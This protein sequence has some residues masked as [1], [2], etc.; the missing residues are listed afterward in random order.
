MRGM[1]M[2]ESTVADFVRRFTSVCAQRTRAQ[3]CSRHPSSPNSPAPASHHD[4][5]IAP[6]SPELTVPPVLVDVACLFMVGRSSPHCSGIG[7]C[8][9]S[10][11]EDGAC[12]GQRSVWIIGDGSLPGF[13][14][15]GP[16]RRRLLSHRRTLSPTLHRK[17]AMEY[18]TGYRA[19]SRTITV[20]TLP[21]S[22][23][24]FK[25]QI[26]GWRSSRS[27]NDHPRCPESVARRSAL[28][29]RITAHRPA[30]SRRLEWIGVGVPASGRMQRLAAR[31]HQ[32]GLMN[33]RATAYALAFSTPQPHAVAS[34]HTMPAASVD[35][36][37]TDATYL[38]S[39]NRVWAATLAK[40]DG[41]RRS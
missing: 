32:P 21:K 13:S 2:S 27:T 11:A 29:P 30:L 26:R 37:R 40:H 36:M 24:Y 35:V 9:T 8:K 19:R 28:S 12:I 17:P 7:R 38:Y 39:Q 16:H 25:L 34:E 6:F 1:Y 22:C 10:R 4:V 14:A 5:T 18:I 3:T 33:G 15:R 20:R 23:A 41:F 31:V